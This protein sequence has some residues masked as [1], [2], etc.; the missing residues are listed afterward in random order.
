MQS[1]ADHRC[2]YNTRHAFFM[3]DTY[4]YKH[5]LRI[6]NTHSFSTATLVARKHLTVTLYAQCLSCLLIVPSSANFSP[7]IITKNRKMAQRFLNRGLKKCTENSF[8]VTNRQSQVRLTPVT[9]ELLE[10]LI[11]PQLL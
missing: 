7:V 5:T 2:H 1:W 3:L 11:N 4:G 6:C 9:R 8:R 10:K